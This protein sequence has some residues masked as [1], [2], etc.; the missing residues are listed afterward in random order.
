M[1]FWKTISHN[2]TISI[3]FS[4]SLSPEREENEDLKGKRAQF[5]KKNEKNQLFS[6]IKNAKF[7]Y[8]SSSIFQIIFQ[9]HAEYLMHISKPC[10]LVLV[11]NP[12]V[13]EKKT[14]IEG[15]NRARVQQNAKK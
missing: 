10:S 8:I 3:K 12:F 14:E 1:K 15:N 6:R 11:F 13:A 4:W 9:Q 5:E 7:I 2:S